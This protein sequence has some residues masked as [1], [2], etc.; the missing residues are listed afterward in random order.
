MMKPTTASRKSGCPGR[1]AGSCR[2]ALGQPD[3]QLIAMTCDIM[4][5]IRVSGM[6]PED[7]DVAVPNPRISGTGLTRIA[8]SRRP[9]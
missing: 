7:V 6:L 9:G 1:P 2:L 4:M 5:M 8:A 3:A